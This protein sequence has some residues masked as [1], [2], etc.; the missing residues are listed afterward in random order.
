MPPLP[1][2]RTTVRVFVETAVTRKISPVRGTNTRSCA[3]KYAPLSTTSDVAEVLYPA[4]LLIASNRGSSSSSCHLNCGLIVA[5]LERRLV[6]C[7]S[8]VLSGSRSRM[9]SAMSI[10][11]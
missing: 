6:N 4:P 1:T 9:E 11:R 8:G 10:R 7:V 3:A 5:F 2:P